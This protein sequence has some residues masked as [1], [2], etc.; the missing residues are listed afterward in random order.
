MVINMEI[1][2][3]HKNEILKS[4]PLIDDMGLKK[5]RI[6]WENEKKMFGLFK[7]WKIESHELKEELRAMHDWSLC[8]YLCFDR[9]LKGNPNYEDYSERLLITTEFNLFELAYALYRDFGDDAINIL[10]LTRSEIMVGHVGDD[11]YLEASEIRLLTNK[12]GKNL[13]LID[14]LGYSCAKKFGMKIS[15]GDREFKDMENVEYLKW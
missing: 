11:D 1:N 8:W 15:T 6:K 9:D 3:S 14:C 7:E 10:R 2:A 4:I 13:S 5:G 12:E